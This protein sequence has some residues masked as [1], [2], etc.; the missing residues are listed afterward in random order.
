MP[1]INMST[2]TI[3]PTTGSACPAWC[4]DHLEIDDN[5]TGAHLR[6][7][8]V[9]AVSVV[10]QWCPTDEQAAGPVIETDAYDWVNGQDARDYAAAIIAAC[11]L[12]DA[13]T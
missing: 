7:V 12:I 4:T 10:I 1:R 8:E 2:T 11:D 5:P 3:Q 13:A 9:G 6:R